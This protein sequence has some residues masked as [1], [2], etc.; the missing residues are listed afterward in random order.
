MRKNRKIY[1]T[2][3]FHHEFQNKHLQNVETMTLKY[4]A[5]FPDYQPQFLCWPSKRGGGGWRAKYVQKSQEKT[6]T[7]QGLLPQFT[8]EQLFMHQQGINLGSLF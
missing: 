6:W 4:I 1:Y 5:L 2:N 8:K 3:L 7:F